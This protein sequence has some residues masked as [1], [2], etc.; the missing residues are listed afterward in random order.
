MWWICCC[1]TGFVLC[2]QDCKFPAIRSPGS[3]FFLRVQRTEKSLAGALT[4][5][6]QPKRALL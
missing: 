1:F 3:H 4:P 2:P 5:T 6:C